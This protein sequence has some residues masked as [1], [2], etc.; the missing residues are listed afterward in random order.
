MRSE[1]LSELFL[2]AGFLAG[3]YRCTGLR[4]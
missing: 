3:I 4:L 1:T 2:A